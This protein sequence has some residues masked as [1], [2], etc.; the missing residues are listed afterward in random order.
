MNKD[1]HQLFIDMNDNQALASAMKNANNEDDVLA[2]GRKFGYD[3]TLKEVLAKIQENNMNT[4]ELGDISAAGS[5]TGNPDRYSINSGEWNNF[6]DHYG[7]S[8]GGE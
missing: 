5:L 3:L 6:W 7:G 1:T 4:Q 2:I 8:Y